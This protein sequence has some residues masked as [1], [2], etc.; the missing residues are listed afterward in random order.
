MTEII[1][2]GPGAIGGA[3]RRLVTELAEESTKPASRIRTALSIS[4]PNQGDGGVNRQAMA[5]ARLEIL[6]DFPG[7]IGCQDER[8]G[9]MKPGETPQRGVGRAGQ[10]SDMLPRGAGGQSRS[11]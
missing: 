8:A 7:A 5:A 1:H 2:A 9:F 3:R 11:R 6:L 10:T 4:R